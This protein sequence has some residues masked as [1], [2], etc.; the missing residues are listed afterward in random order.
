[1]QYLRRPVEG[2]GSASAGVT[3]QLCAAYNWEPNTRPPEE[4]QTILRAKPFLQPKDNFMTLDTTVIIFFTEAREPRGGFWDFKLYFSFV[5]KAN[6]NWY[7][8]IPLG[9]TPLWSAHSLPARSAI[10]P[11]T[12]DIRT[13]LGLKMGWERR[14]S[15]YPM[16]LNLLSCLGLYRL[17]T[18]LE[19]CSFQSS[20]LLP[21]EVPSSSDALWYLGML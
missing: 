7:I 14:L 16:V 11:G 12:E 17:V 1:M 9:C 18:L 5:L 19:E 8:L 2:V 15:G 13:G 21:D 6:E 10:I 3:G 4:Q 20:S